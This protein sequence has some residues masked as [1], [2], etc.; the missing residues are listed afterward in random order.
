M[1]RNTGLCFHPGLKVPCSPLFLCAHVLSHVARAH[2][3]AHTHTKGDARTIPGLHCRHSDLAVAHRQWLHSS[4]LLPSPL[5]LLLFTKQHRTPLSHPEEKEQNLQGEHGGSVV[6]L[7]AGEQHPFDWK[8][9]GQGMAPKA[10][11]L[12]RCLFVH[13]C[14]CVP[15]NVRVLA[16]CICA[17]PGAA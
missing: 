10:C 15:F 1:A 7:C 14:V 9:R 8:T 5:L 12:R 3:L 16:F 13:A 2:A 4:V 17:S 11:W 6:L